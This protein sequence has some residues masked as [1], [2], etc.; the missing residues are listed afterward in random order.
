[1]DGSVESI[2][3]VL[4]NDKP[5]TFGAPD[6]LRVSIEQVTAKYV[7]DQQFHDRPPSQVR[8]SASSTSFYST[9]HGR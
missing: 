8:L 9:V 4:C 6:V 5:Q 2:S 1:M 7:M 3:A